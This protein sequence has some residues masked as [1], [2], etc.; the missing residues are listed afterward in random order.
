MN[1]TDSQLHTKMLADK[2]FENDTICIQSE[3]K[4]EVTI[5]TMTV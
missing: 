4:K 1:T 2:H 3:L 5:L